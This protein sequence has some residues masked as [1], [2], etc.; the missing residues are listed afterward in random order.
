VV[1]FFLSTTVE[2]FK[3]LQQQNLYLL[4]LNSKIINEEVMNIKHRL[5]TKQFINFEEDQSKH[6]KDVWKRQKQITWLIPRNK[7]PFP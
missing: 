4:I 7:L 3:I 6:W 1:T 2:E 5:K